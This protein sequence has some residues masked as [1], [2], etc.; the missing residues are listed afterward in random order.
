MKTLSR[1]DPDGNLP[2]GCPGTEPSRGPK[3]TIKPSF[4]DYICCDRLRQRRLA[5]LRHGHGAGRGEKT[6]GGRHRVQGT[7]HSGADPDTKENISIFSWKK[8]LESA[9]SDSCVFENNAH[10][11]GGRN[12]C[13]PFSLRSSPRSP[14]TQCWAMKTRCRPFETIRNKR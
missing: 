11:S 10:L 13:F 3:P 2:S 12:C 5:V 9:I 8:Q 7:G 6:E 14:R 4:I 1:F